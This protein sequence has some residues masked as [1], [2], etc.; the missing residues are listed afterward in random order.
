LFLEKNE[1]KFT[2]LKL[3]RNSLPS[4]RSLRPLVFDTDL[5]WFASLSLC[6]VIFIVTALIGF[7]LL[8]SQY[9][10]TYKQSK[11]T[12]NY[13]NLININRLKSAIDKRNSFINQQIS[14]P[15]DPSL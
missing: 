4:L 5:F 7:K 15:R 14:L 9:F 11:P 12:E 10:E 8:Y 2:F 3:K 1:M 13:E 6:L